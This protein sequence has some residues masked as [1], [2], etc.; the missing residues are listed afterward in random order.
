MVYD[1]QLLS[2]KDVTRLK[3]FFDIIKSVHHFNQF[4]IQHEADDLRQIP[5]T[6]VRKITETNGYSIIFCIDPII[7]IIKTIYNRVLLIDSDIHLEDIQFLDLTTN[8]SYIDNGIK[9][10]ITPEKFRKTK[11]LKYSDNFCIVPL[12]LESIYYAGN[13]TISKV[14]AK[15]GDF[16]FFHQESFFCKKIT[17]YPIFLVMYYNKVRNKINVTRLL[18]N[19]GNDTK[20][21]NLNLQDKIL[22]KPITHAL[23][24]IEDIILKIEEL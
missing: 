21:T 6:I 9:N 15:P 19:N 3:Y 18:K 17:Y 13:K 10:T 14:V 24:N 20:N 5:N 12:N 23:K 4:R 2:K 22:N 11:A 8:L 1:K 7:D 16:L